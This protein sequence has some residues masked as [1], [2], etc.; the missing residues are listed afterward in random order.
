MANN[1]YFGR[2][3]RLFMVQGAN[4]WEIPMLNGFGFSQTANTSEVTLNEMSDAAGTSR[5]GRTM[6]TDSQAPAEWSF[7]TYVRPTISA[8]LHRSLEEPLWANFVANNAY[9][10]GAW[11]ANTVNPVSTTSQDIKFTN[12]NKTELGKFDLVFV[13][14]GN[15]AATAFDTGTG[16]TSTTAYGIKMYR[17][18]DASINEVSIT[19][20]IDGIA[21]LSWS[22][23][24][25]R[26]REYGPT[27]SAVGALAPGIA[28]T[29][30]FI[31]NRL[32]QV[33][34]IRKD[35]AG[36]TIK[37]YGITLTGGTITMS[38]NMTYLTP[39]VLG[40]VNVPLGHITGTRSV[41]GSFTCYLDST[42][43]G[44]AE[45]VDDLSSDITNNRNYF[46]LSFYVGGTSGTTDV[47]RAPGVLF[48]I[49]KAHLTIPSMDTGD[50]IALS[51]D[52]TALPTDM[53]T[54]DEIDLIRYIGVA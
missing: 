7:D 20:D 28:Q 30:N 43:L 52:F 24:G 18:Y 9:A 36:A 50:V 6:F 15:S 39:E 19:F 53:G 5:R 29:N 33:T 25:A 4:V 49:P 3:T 10:T 54:P 45:L 38:N 47:P 44:S 34:A 46:D 35:A 31:R 8:T 16:V 32:T 37:T 21:T 22:G 14:G 1:I 2:D 23:M 12:S 13:V 17:I 27:F 41:G 51:V 42:T 48:S 26:M 40:R 11:G